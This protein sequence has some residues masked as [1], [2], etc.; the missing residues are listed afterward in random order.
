MSLERTFYLT[1]GVGMLGVLVFF[2]VL[3]PRTED[4]ALSRHSQT[5]TVD[6]GV[7]DMDWVDPYGSDRTP[8]SQAYIDEHGYG[9]A[10]CMDDG[11]CN[12]GSLKDDVSSGGAYYSDNEGSDY[13]G[14]DYNEYWYDYPYGQNTSSYVGAGLSQVPMVLANVLSP[15]TQTTYQAYSTSYVPVQQPI[16]PV[17]YQQ[18]VQYQQSY[19]SS[20]TQSQTQTYTV[21]T[22]SYTSGNNYVVTQPQVANIV[23]R[24]QVAQQTS[25][26]YYIAQP[27]Q[28]S[29]GSFFATQAPIQ[30]AI[31]STRTDAEPAG[32]AKPSCTLSA[33]PSRIAAGATTTISWKV[34]NADKAG[35]APGQSVSLVGS[36]T[37]MLATTTMYTLTATSDVG[38]SSCSVKVTI[39]P[40]MCAPGCPPGYVCTPVVA[41]A[42]AAAVSATTTKKGFW[43][44]L[45]F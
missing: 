25:G 26:T 23:S 2:P 1:L 38:T 37:V 22:G 7:Q 10:P 9:Y 16:Q 35:F 19:A 24:G 14:Y 32:P 29:S 11:S 5:A 12:A 15:Q 31:S 41:P 43:S 18:P 13:Y 30:V 4:F 20:P 28:T 6:D 44:W 3:F 17:Y 39:D 40:T 34:S 42:P 27:V 36:S 8:D 21:T 45:G 33:K